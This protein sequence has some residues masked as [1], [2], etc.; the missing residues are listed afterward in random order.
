MDRRS[1]LSVGIINLIC[2]A[3]VFIL[4]LVGFFHLKGYIGYTS[5][6]LTSNE[7]DILRYVIYMGIFLIVRLYI[8][9]FFGFKG[10][11]ILALINI[12]FI[13]IFTSQNLGYVY[14]LKLYDTNYLY[15]TA[16]FLYFI[17]SIGYSYEEIYFAFYDAGKYKYEHDIILD[18]DYKNGI[19]HR[20]FNFIYIALILWFIIEQTNIIEINRYL[21]CVVCIIVNVGVSNTFT[22]KVLLSTGHKSNRFLLLMQF[23]FFVLGIYLIIRY[24]NTDNTMCLYVGII[25]ILSLFELLF[26]CRYKIVD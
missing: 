19:Y 23:I 5:E 16:S 25:Y 14:A 24:F 4:M 21:I 22:E 6:L 26:I 13:I 3:V 18:P 15:I 8:Y 17:I 2:N 7:A 20:I 9:T 10:N 12:I 11:T 1:D